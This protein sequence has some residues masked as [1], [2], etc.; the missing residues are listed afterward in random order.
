MDRML[1]GE[2]GSRTRIVFDLVPIA[3]SV[4]S[5]VKA[6]ENIPAPGGNGTERRRRAVAVFH[7]RRV[8]FP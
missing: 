1:E 2:R 5:G 3:T 4:E 6:A 8:G 7:R